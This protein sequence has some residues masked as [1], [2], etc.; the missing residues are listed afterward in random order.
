MNK[1]NKAGRLAAA[2]VLI[3]VLMLIFGT[4]TVNSY[5]AEYNVI[6]NTVI[7]TE[8]AATGTDESVKADTVTTGADTAAETTEKPSLGERLANK[9]SGLPDELVCFIVSMIP[10]VELRGGLI[11]AAIKGLPLWRAIAVCIAGNLVPIPFILLLITPIFAWLKKTK[12][13]RPIVEKLEKKSMGKS[14]KIKKYEFLGLVLFVGIPL[15]GTGAWTGSLIASLLEIKFKKAFPAICL[16]L[17]MATIIM[18]F[19]TYGIPWLVSN[20]F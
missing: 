8:M 4:F 16:G 14:D 19:I 10:V 7:M 5:A 17:I 2:T 18:C 1:R 9:L 15:P 6:R 12:L 20:V 13:F 11:V 3:S